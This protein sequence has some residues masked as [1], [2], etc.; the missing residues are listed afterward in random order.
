MVPEH[1]AAVSRVERVV[2]VVDVVGVPH[3]DQPVRVIEPPELRLH[4]EHEPIRVGRDPRRL[5]V[6]P[7]APRLVVRAR[8]LAL[9]VEHCLAFLALAFVPL[10]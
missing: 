2:L 7:G 8:H 6:L 9:L 4:V 10:V 5:G 3:L 1:R